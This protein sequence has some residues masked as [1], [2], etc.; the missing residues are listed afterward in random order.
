MYC[1]WKPVLNYCIVIGIRI[2]KNC[3]M[4]PSCLWSRV[5]LIV[6]DMNGTVVLCFVLLSNDHHSITVLAVT[7]LR[8]SDI[9]LTSTHDNSHNVHQIKDRLNFPSQTNHQWTFVIVVT[10]FSVSVTV[11]IDRSD[12]NNRVILIRR[13]CCSLTAIRLQIMLLR[14]GAG[15]LLAKWQHCTYLCGEL[16]RL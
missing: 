11:L 4:I 5:E 9:K 8:Q 6:R 13:Y 1:S 3:W 10:Q 14:E 12:N 2:L 7:S 15:L 16:Q